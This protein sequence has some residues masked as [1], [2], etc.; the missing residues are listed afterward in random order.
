M[1]IRIIDLVKIVD[2]VART[3]ALALFLKLI[4]GCILALR[5]GD[6][7]GHARNYKRFQ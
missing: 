2:A 5:T 6:G 1:A 4:A 7:L 3:L